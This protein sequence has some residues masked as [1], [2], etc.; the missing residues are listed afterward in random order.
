MPYWDIGAGMIWTDLSGQ[1]SEQSTNFNFVL[2]TGPGVQYFLTH[3]SA[4][5][6]GTRFHHISNSGIGERNVGLN[7]FLGYLGVSFFF[8]R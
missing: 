5:T 2:E 1:I 8:P 7:A 4:L 6:F 3:R